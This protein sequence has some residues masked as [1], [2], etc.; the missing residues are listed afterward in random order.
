MHG[1]L[2]VKVSRPNG[3]KIGHF[4]DIPQAN[5]LAWYATK[6]NTTKADIHQSKEMYNKINTK[7]V[8]RFPGLVSSYDIQPGKREGLFWFRHFINQSL[9]QTLTHL[10][11]APDPHGGGL[12][13]TDFKDCKTTVVVT[14]AAVKKIRITH[15]STEITTQHTT[16]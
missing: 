1:W 6:P 13:G 12:H 3:H 10:L 16:P 7:N 2:L 14:T 15:Q 4:G 5:L 9:T 11:T 8:A